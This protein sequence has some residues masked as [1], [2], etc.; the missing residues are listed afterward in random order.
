[1]DRLKKVPIFIWLVYGFIAIG[2]DGMIY[3]GI[4]IQYQKQGYI[5][6]NTDEIFVLCLV[7]IFNVAAVLGIGM[8][9]YKVRNIFK[10]IRVIFQGNPLYSKRK[11]NGKKYSTKSTFKFYGGIMLMLTLTFWLGYILVVKSQELSGYLIIA[12]IVFVL[13][14]I[15]KIYTLC[16]KGGINKN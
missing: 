1:M 11:D 4:Q 13:F 7:F 15:Y 2:W 6:F 8:V 5:S 16:I 10:K 14:T 12:N 9:L 3:K